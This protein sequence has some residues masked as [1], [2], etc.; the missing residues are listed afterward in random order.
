[1]E[2]KLIFNHFNVLFF[3]IEDKIDHFMKFFVKCMGF[4]KTIGVVLI[5]GDGENKG[6]TA[7]GTADWDSGRW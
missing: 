1:M 2:I 6:K 4:D 3:R 7:T 5:C